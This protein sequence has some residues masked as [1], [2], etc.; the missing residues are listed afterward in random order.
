MDGKKLNDLV[1]TG[2]IVL[3]HD[4]RAGMNNAG[5]EHW[6]EKNRRLGSTLM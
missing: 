6:R 5:Y 4:S 2:D 3:L 1:F